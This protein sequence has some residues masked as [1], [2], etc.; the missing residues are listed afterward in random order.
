MA[1]DFEDVERDIPFI[2]DT[3]EEAKA[4]IQADA[5]AKGYEIATKR[6]HPDRITNELRRV[7]L[8][9]SRGVT[10]KARPSKKPRDRNTSTIKCDCPWEIRVLRLKEHKKWEVVVIDASHNHEPAEEASA[11]PGHRRRELNEVLDVIEQSARQTPAEIVD[12]FRKSNQ[13]TTIQLKDI[14][15]V[16]RRLR[17]KRLGKYTPTQLLL[18][19]LHRD[20]C[21]V[22]FLLEDKSKRVSKL[23]RINSIYKTDFEAGQKTIFRQ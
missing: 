11:L 17:R 12:R 9:C 22:K 2:Y 14:Y 21:F 4:T 7:V 5:K 1:S 18:K 6:S 19:A 3:I 20:N 13:G 16:K 8:V 10:Y 15:N 23:S